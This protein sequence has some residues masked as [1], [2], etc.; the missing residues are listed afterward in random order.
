MEPEHTTATKGINNKLPA[1]QTRSY[2]G[3]KITPK[4]KYSK[5]KLDISSKISQ[6]GLANLTWVARLTS[7]A[8]SPGILPQSLSERYQTET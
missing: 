7:E 5:A 6:P 8:S 4:P 1:A 2:R 3:G